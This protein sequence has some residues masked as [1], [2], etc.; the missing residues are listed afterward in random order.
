MNKIQVGM[1]VQYFDGTNYYPSLVYRVIDEQKMILSLVVF[2]P[3]AR[4]VDNVESVFTHSPAYW[5]FIPEPR[6]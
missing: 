3:H 1:N 6:N 5:R 4:Q 2:F